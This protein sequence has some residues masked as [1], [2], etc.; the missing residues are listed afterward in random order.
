MKRIIKNVFCKDE[1]FYS[2]FFTIAIPVAIQSFFGA[3]V[4]LIDNFMVGQLGD[5]SVASVGLSNQF[6]FI[7]HLIMFALSS[8][9][10]VFLAQY[11]GN[12][13][14]KNMKKIM[15]ISLI[16]T[17]SVAFL[18]F[19]AAFIRPD[20][21]LSIFSEDFEVIEL[22]SS[23]ITIVSFSYIIIPFSLC[24]GTASRNTGNIKLPL[25]ANA[26]GIALNAVLNYIL[27]FGKLGFPQLGVVGA[28]LGTTIARLIEVV[29]LLS[30]IYFKKHIIAA[31]PKELFNISL[32]LLK[33]FILTSGGLVIKDTVWVLGVSTYMAIYAR[34]ATEA[35]TA[36]NIVDT[37]RRLLT[38]FFHGVSSACLIMVGNQIG[39]RLYDKAYLYAK[40]FLSITFLGSLVISAVTISSRY[41]FLLPYDISEQAHTWAGNV[42]F[43]LGFVLILDLF[44]MVC[45]IGVLRSGGDVNFCLILDVVCVWVI[46]FPM[47]ILGAYVLKL[48]LE[49]VY[50]MVMSQEIFKF[51]M[52]YRRFKS[53]KWINDLVN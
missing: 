50:A 43:I 28:G 29:I 3:A 51:I 26:I 32:S 11:W 5:A 16:L 7:L 4:N 8:G 36:I 53:K 35:A 15:G 41:L 48:P 40:R 37:I 52:C 27:I 24:Y 1:E 38:V 19:L 18:F 12:R 45:I 17:F 23:Y 47:A 13:D 9:G 44:N 10:A 33:R 14:I 42:L 34:M 25:I 39:A 46:G 2:R 30:V 21:V 49:A 31:K 20:I 6:Y 22:G